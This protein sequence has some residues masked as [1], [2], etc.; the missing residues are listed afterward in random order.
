MNYVC[1]FSSFKSNWLQVFTQKAQEA[2]SQQSQEAESSTA[3]PVSHSS[4]LLAAC[5]ALN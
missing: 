3:L 1:L 4:V 2:M 5:T